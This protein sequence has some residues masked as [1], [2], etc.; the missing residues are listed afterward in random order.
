MTQALLSY[1]RRKG[2]TVLQWSE[3]ASEWLARARCAAEWLPEEAWPALDDETLLARLELWLEP[4]LAGV[5]SVKGLQSVSVLQALKHY[6]GWELSQQLDEWL[7][8]HHLLPT[9]NHKNPLSVRDGAYALGAHAG[10]VWRAKFATRC[11]RDAR[12]GDG[13]AF[14]RAAT[15][16]SYPRSRQFW[17]GAY[18]EVQKE[19]KGRYPKHVWPDD[20]ANHV[21]TS[22]TKRQL[23]A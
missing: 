23:N 10:S 8:T 2:L 14:P 16:A 1:V 4:Y 18:K 9:G 3:D 22:K 12:R 5:T 20:P 21:A 15:V 13:T 6:L 11:Q 7:P 17:A 19:M